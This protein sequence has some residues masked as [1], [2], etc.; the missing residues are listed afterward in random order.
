MLSFEQFKTS[1]IKVSDDCP[2]VHTGNSLAWKHKLLFH[3][4]AIYA[5]A[6]FEDHVYI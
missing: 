1:C 4:G 5:K 3:R 2:F 6:L